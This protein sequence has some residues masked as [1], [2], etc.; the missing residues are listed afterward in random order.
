[1]DESGSAIGMEQRSKVILPIEEK[2]AFSKQD[3]NREWATLVECIRVIGG[4]IP[5]FLIVKGQYILE[6]MCQLFGD[7]RA[8]LAVSD[9][10]WTNDELGVEWLRHFNRYTPSIGAYRLLILDNHGSH[11]TIAF[12]DYA[13]ENKIVLLYLPSHSTHRLQSLDIAIF[14]PLATYYSH[15]V[16]AYSRYE[17]KGVSKREWM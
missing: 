1:M 3:G 13:Y 10:G 5:P 9:N 15:E 2:E 4:D 17:G 16:N 11:A 6:D 14:G 7:S 8:T 12:I